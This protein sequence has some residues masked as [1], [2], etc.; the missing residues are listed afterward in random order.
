[1]EGDDEVGSSDEEA[2]D[3]RRRPP[4]GC[5]SS[6]LAEGLPEQEDGSE[7]IGVKIVDSPTYSFLFKIIYEI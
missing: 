1:M 6:P 3:K 5:G 2:E 7:K 4:H